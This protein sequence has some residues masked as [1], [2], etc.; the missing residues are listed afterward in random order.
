MSEYAAEQRA[1][2]DAKVIELRAEGWDVVA[3]RERDLALSK[4][5]D[6]LDEI[7]S[8]H[9]LA[10]QALDALDAEKEPDHERG[11]DKAIGALLAML[12][13]TAVDDEA[14]AAASE[15]PPRR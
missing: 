1:K 4:R 8:L 7:A 10:R 15:L 5:D 12:G 2:L 14:K 9:G 13:K 6:A 11:Y 3:R